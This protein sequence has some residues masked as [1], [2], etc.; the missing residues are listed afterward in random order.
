MDDLV[1]E[2]GRRKKVE[3]VSGPMD[4]DVVHMLKGQDLSYLRMLRSVNLAKLV[5][6]ASAAAAA[7]DGS[8]APKGEKK[9]HVRFVEDAR[10]GMR[11]A[12]SLVAAPSKSLALASADPQE[13][14]KGR[15][16]RVRKLDIAI[17][18]LEVQ[19]NAMGKG[20]KRKVGVDANGVPIYKYAMER[21]K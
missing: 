19:R 10:E 18:Q 14:V 16:E 9:Q 7:N 8:A 2:E 13:A 3:E 1:D 12:R 11:L 15:Q 17:R 5:H 4:T 20:K 6:P 21:K